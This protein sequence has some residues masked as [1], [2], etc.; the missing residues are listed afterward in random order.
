MTAAKAGRSSTD[1][2]RADMLSSCDRIEQEVSEARTQ[3]I[4]GLADAPQAV[5]GH[6]RVVDVEKALDSIE[7]S[8]AEVRAALRKA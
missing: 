1:H 5:R 2:D 3:I 7:T 8:L 6:S 4:I